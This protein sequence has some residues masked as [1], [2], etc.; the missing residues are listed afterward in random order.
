[1]P[2][3]IY[4]RIGD[5]A[6]L[7]GVSVD[8]MRRWADE[9]VVTAYRSPGGQVKF[10][11]RDVQE[12]LTR[13]DTPSRIRRAGEGPSDA[14]AEEQEEGA[15]RVQRSPTPKWQD[16]APWEKRRAEVETELEIERL[17]ATREQERAAED[18]QLLEDGSRAAEAVRLTE[19]KRF[20]RLCCWSFEATSE[21]VRELE[22]FVTS[23]QI[24]PWLSKWEQT[25]VVQ[26]FVQEVVEKVKVE[27]AA[28]KR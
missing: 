15:P 10:R 21:V 11:Q 24:P 26:T 1:M 6:R 23:E 13:R 3:E 14:T 7:L 9:G 5:A 8:T 20:G 22:R 27:K 28:K 19:L 18:R 16:L 12:L 25:Q 4:V 2:S 17:T